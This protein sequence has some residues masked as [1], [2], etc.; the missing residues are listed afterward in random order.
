MLMLN[1]HASHIA[2]ECGAHA[3]TDI[4]GFALLGHAKEMAARSNAGIVIEAASVPVLPGAV[5]YARAGILTGGAARNRTGLEG[6]VTVAAGVA[7]EVQDLLFDP[8]TSGGLLF[9]LPPSE[10]HEAVG[11]LITDGLTAAVVGRVVEGSG[12]HVE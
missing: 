5:D 10:A 3:M 11:R 7:T 6:I 4:T 12:V 1:R 9:A 8:Q 2:A